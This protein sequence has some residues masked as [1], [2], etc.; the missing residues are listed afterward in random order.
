M[1]FFLLNLPPIN[2]Y[3]A[4][5]IWPYYNGVEFA[6]M[7]NT[8]VNPSSECSQGETRVS[9]V[10][11]EKLAMHNGNICQAKCKLDKVTQM[12]VGCNRSIQEITRA[13]MEARKNRLT[14]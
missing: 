9:E 13:G 6:R 2:L 5:L 14:R 1:D 8:I 12:C 11:V 7:N 3:T 10:I 4:N